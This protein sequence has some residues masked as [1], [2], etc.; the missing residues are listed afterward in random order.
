AIFKKEMKRPYRS[1]TKMDTFRKPLAVFFTVSFVI[2]AVMAIVLF[3]FDRRAFTAE[4]YQQ[5]FAR[6]DFYNQIPNLMAQ[7][8]AASAD[9]NQL[10]AVM[11]GMSLE[12]W[13]SFIRVLLPP[14]V[15]KPIGD[16]VLVSTFGYLNMESDLVQVNLTP[17]KASMISDTGTQ[18]VLSLLNTFLPAPS[19]RSHR[20]PSTSLQAGRSNFVT[21]QP[22]FSRCLPR[23]FRDRCKLL[24]HSSPIS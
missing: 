2:T 6:E 10:P 4:T 21:R 11:Q 5:A 9:T 24:R 12:A 22:M 16:D 3:N 14:E 1:H 17:V 7:S 8:I 13:E 15:L 19:I 18:A 23:S 20:S